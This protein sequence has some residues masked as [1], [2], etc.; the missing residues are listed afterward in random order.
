[1]ATTELLYVPSQ[2]GACSS[3]PRGP[4]DN[5]STLAGS[6]GGLP[7]AILSQGDPAPEEG[8]RLG[9]MLGVPA[10]PVALGQAG[11]TVMSPYRGWVMF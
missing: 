11:D 10:A 2:A 1:M 6:K 4:G 7:L 8:C 9:E 3:W 5:L